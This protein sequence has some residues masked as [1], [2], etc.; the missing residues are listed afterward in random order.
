ML[1]D[2]L[3]PLVLQNAQPPTTTTISAALLPYLR[4]TAK[5]SLCNRVKQRAL[6][7]VEGGHWESVR[8][9]PR[10]VELLLTSARIVTKTSAEAVDLA[11]LSA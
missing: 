10:Y 9:L 5:R 4:K 8:V 11:M 1:A 7:L 6:E 3:T 2:L